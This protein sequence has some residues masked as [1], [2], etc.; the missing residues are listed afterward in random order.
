MREHQRILWHI[1]AVS[2]SLLFTDRFGEIKQNFMFH[3]PLDY[4]PSSWLHSFCQSTTKEAERCCEKPQG[5]SVLTCSGR[6]P[7]GVL[8]CGSWTD[9]EVCENI[10]LISS[11]HVQLV[12]L[13]IDCM[14]EA[15][16]K[17]RIAVF[18]VCYILYMSS[19]FALSTT[20]WTFE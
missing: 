2:G 11:S 14:A 12:P 8:P 3:F 9:W 18:N 5:H 15:T 1:K 7:V 16:L 17:W 19:Y 6:Y 10:T 20:M 4:R 13:S